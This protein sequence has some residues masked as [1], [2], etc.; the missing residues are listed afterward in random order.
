MN[1]VGI[2]LHARTVGEEFPGHESMIR[3]GVIA[4]QPHLFVHIERHHILKSAHIYLIRCYM[5]T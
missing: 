1:N 5:H 4:W 3:L 2:R